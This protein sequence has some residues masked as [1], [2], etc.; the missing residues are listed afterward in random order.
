MCGYRVKWNC[1]AKSYESAYDL[2][3]TGWGVTSLFLE[4]GIEILKETP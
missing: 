1:V 2:F 3:R 4:R